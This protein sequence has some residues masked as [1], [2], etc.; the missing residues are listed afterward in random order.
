MSQRRG[1][2]R[3]LFT[4]AR[5]FRDPFYH[6]SV[7]TCENVTAAENPLLY[8]YRT[9]GKP[10]L[11]Y[12]PGRQRLLPSFLSWWLFFGMCCWIDSDI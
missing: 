10:N 1:L 4:C 11:V 6:T 2:S 12:V 3:P 7:S 8:V 5:T 9:E